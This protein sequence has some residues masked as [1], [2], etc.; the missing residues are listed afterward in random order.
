MTVEREHFKQTITTMLMRAQYQ[1]GVDGT[2][3]NFFVQDVASE[4]FGY[5]ALAGKSA[6]E[7]VDFIGAV[8]PAWTAIYDRPLQPATANAPPPRPDPQL[9]AALAT[10]ARLV[11]GP[12]VSLV[13][14]GYAPRIGHGH[15]AVGYPHA[16]ERSG[17]WGPYA[18]DGVPYIAQAGETVA[19]T[20]LS[21]GFRVARLE[22]GRFLIAHM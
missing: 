8:H 21:E 11:N 4:L 5:T 6:N 17:K 15:V 10:V 12:E 1:P 7:I 14:V 2:K 19:A 16:L 22:T 9:E 18:P 13:V 20:K 3:C